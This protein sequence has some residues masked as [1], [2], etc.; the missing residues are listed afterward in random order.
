MKTDGSEEI[1]VI[2]WIKN[3]SRAEWCQRIPKN[4]WMS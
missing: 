3:A 4:L 1:V 2:P